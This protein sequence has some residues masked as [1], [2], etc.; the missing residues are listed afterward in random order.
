MPPQTDLAARLAAAERRY[1]AL[2]SQLAQ[3]GLIAP[4]S[5][6]SRYTR[7]GKAGCRCQADPPRLHG[8]YWQWTAII[9]GKTV[10]RRLTEPQAQRYREWVANDRRLRKLIPQLRRAANDAIDLTLQADQ[11]DPAP[12]PSPS[13]GG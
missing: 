6:V 4:G 12:A 5:V 9:D 3:I 1:H 13:P 2:S 8:P 10:T 11:S 7:C